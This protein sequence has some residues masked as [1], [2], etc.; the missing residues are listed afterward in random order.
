MTTLLACPGV[1]GAA[2]GAIASSIVVSTGSG[3]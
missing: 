2:S 1:I 3:S